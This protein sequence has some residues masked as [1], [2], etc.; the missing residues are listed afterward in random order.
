MRLAVKNLEQF[1]KV[2]D[3]DMESCKSVYSNKKPKVKMRPSIICQF[4]Y[5]NRET[6]L[7][8]KYLVVYETL[9]EPTL[10]NI[11]DPKKFEVKFRKY[12]SSII[13][14]S[15]ELVARFISNSELEK[16]Y[17]KQNIMQLLAKISAKNIQVIYNLQG[18][19]L[20]TYDDERLNSIGVILINDEY[21]NKFYLKKLP[22]REELIK[23]HILIKKYNFYAL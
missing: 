8:L 14:L 4:N 7:V 11:E 18:E 3:W 12:P 21:S 13:N 10:S 2:G 6:E 1:Y 19:I 20:V 23:T 9:N 17:Y 5:F 15:V 16:D 22:T